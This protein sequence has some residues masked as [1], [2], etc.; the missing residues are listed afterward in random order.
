MSEL[1]ARVSERYR[2]GHDGEPP[3]LFGDHWLDSATNLRAAAVLVAITDRSDEDG[4]PGVLLLH[5]PSDMRA[6]PGQIALP[7]GKIDAGETPTEA[8]LREAWEELGIDPGLVRIIGESD[9]YKTHSGFAITPVLGIVPPDITITPS[10]AEVAQWFEAPLG[11]VLDPANQRQQTT[12]WEGVQRTYYEIDWRG[13]HIWG[14]TAAL[15]V[16][17]SRRLRWHD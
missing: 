10:P 17:L 1:A 16:N 13:H 3:A 8:A 14:V 6:H 11:F 9:L 15:L 7:G 2:S 5:R 12:V 4:G